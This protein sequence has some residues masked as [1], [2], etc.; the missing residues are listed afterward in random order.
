MIRSYTTTQIIAK[1]G[2]NQIA[3]ALMVFLCA[4]ALS[5]MT[6]IFFALLIF[7]VLFYRNPERLDTE[8]D[9]HALIAPIDGQVIAI[10]KV[11]AN[12]G[13]DWLR[14]V[15]RKRMTDVGVL[16]APMF[17]SEMEVK[18][19]FGLPL[20]GTSPLAKALREKIVFTC[21]SDYA[22]IK[23]VVYAGVFSQKIQ[24]FD[25][26]N[27]LKRSERFAFLN[28]GEV[29][30]MLPLDTRIQVV[31]NDEVKAGESVLGYFA[32]EGK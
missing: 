29:A 8:E 17:I 16:R 28:D 32:Y 12:D 2:W 9:S 11:S 20:A 26:I 23:M 19:R 10:S 5:F 31:L 21:K 27:G 1:E 30:L 3:I 7:T 4:Y 14:V 24:L 13:K 22:E 15:I 6:W 18:K 25:K